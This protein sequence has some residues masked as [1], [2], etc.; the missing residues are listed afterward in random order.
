MMLLTQFS[1]TPPV[2]SVKVR[3]KVSHLYR[4]GKIKILLQSLLFYILNYIVTKI[5]IQNKVQMKI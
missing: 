3:D 2:T 5:S 4:T 1:P